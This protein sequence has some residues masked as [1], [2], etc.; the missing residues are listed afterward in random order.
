M[1]SPF[2]FIP[3]SEFPH[4]AQHAVGYQ[5]TLDRTQC[6][7][8]LKQ[9][10]LDVAKIQVGG[11]SR[12][13]TATSQPRPPSALPASSS[14]SAATAL[15]EKKLPSAAGAGAVAHQP[16]TQQQQEKRTGLDSIFPSAASPP[17]SPTKK[18]K[19]LPA[20]VE[21][22][23]EKENGKNS[24]EGESKQTEKKKEK[25]KS[26]QKEPEDPMHRTG[27]DTIFGAALTPPGPTTTSAKGST[28][29]LKQAAAASEQAEATHKQQKPEQKTG[30]PS[31]TAPRPHTPLPSPQPQAPPPSQQAQPQQPQ[32]YLDTLDR[33]AAKAWLKN[34]RD[35]LAGGVPLNLDK[36]RAIL[37]L[38][39]NAHTRRNTIW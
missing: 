27:L 24:K 18:E 8:L 38:Q 17:A 28:S 37:H 6:I 23:N 1:T 15:L 21:A 20:I 29:P 39:R 19:A 32:H 14:S 2:P 31:T 3:P 36:Y 22:N 5:E 9:A 11:L 26:R 7:A 4:R 13:S 16:Q 30:A 25:E 33:N 34:T 12:P 35:G 10:A